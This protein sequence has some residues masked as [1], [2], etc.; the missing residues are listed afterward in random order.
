[1]SDPKRTTPSSRLDAL[2]GEAKRDLAP[3]ISDAKWSALEDRIL[4][5]MAAKPAAA[6]SASESPREIAPRARRTNVLQIGAAVLAAAAA[7]AMMVKKD[8][9]V[10][11]HE[12]D[13]ARVQVA[14]QSEL[15]AGSLR[16]M[17]GTGE[18]RVG[19]RAVSAGQVLRAGDVIEADGARALL[20]RPRKVTWLLEHGNTEGS[21]IGRARVKSAGEALVLGLEDGAIEAQ[22]T[23][24]RSGEAFAVDIAATTAAGSPSLVRVAVHGTHLR[25]SRLG[26][27]VVVDLTEGVVSIGVP[28]RDVGPGTRSTYGTLVTAPSHVEFD[29]ADLEHTL[30]VEHAP[31]TVRTPVALAFND[32]VT[33][34]AAG[35]NAAAD[36][37]RAPEAPAI[38]PVA[39]ATV[40]RPAAV[41]QR[42]VTDPTHPT[43]PAPVTNVDPRK[44]VLPPREA[45]A[46]AVRGCAAQRSRPENVRV[47]VSSSLQLKIAPDGEVETALFDP[48]L[49]PDI[50]SC[51][52]AEIYKAK[53]E[54]SA[55]TT[56]T[57]PIDFSY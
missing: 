51:A 7:V 19:G 24:V 45:I 57:I 30:R 32:A 11:P 18:I 25:V 14:A 34:R 5:E 6:K 37:P 54:A 13:T 28:P 49:L 40:P 9:A 38:V 29:A 12:M 39:P 36:A 53:I 4:A 47:S 44:P 41:V 26:S 52:A 43:H 56:V 15:T 50:Q 21:T 3:R 16:E 22:V 46:A 35:V 31:A 27:R 1:V 23:P 55:G 33:S 10:T 8:P 48:P 17:V 2:V 42:P 20:E